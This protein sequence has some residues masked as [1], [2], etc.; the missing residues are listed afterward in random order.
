[1]FGDRHLDRTMPNATRRFLFEEAGDG[2][3]RVGPHKFPACAAA[4]PVE[5]EEVYQRTNP[6]G[7][8][9]EQRELGRS[10]SPASGCQREEPNAKTE[11]GAEKNASRRP[12]ATTEQD[13]PIGD[14][15]TAE[16]TEPYVPGGDGRS[17]RS[18]ASKVPV[19][20]ER[21]RLREVE[22]NNLPRFWRSVASPGAWKG[23]GEE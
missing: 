23:P 11:G 7:L 12:G 15:R 2:L 17:A 6:G 8:R 22:C 10:N 3:A 21:S 20:A 18:R 16:E 1:M 9:E 14:E 4:T 19:G 13:V 5:P